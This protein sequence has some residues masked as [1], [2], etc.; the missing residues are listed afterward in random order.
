MDASQAYTKFYI[1]PRKKNRMK[2]KLKRKP[3]PELITAP[4]PP[5]KVNISQLE[6]D[7][8]VRLCPNFNP[9]AFNIIIKT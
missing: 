5:P 2:P 7:W 3:V 9:N 1:L 6:Y 4:A 8:F